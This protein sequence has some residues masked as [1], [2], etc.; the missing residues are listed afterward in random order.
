MFE[1]IVPI[2]SQIFLLPLLCAF[3]VHHTHGFEQVVPPTPR[4]YLGLHAGPGKNIMETTSAA[5][6]ELTT[7]LPNAKTHRLGSH[8]GGTNKVIREDVTLHTSPW[9]ALVAEASN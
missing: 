9:D 5:P 3:T 6:N 2:T 8:V 4:L 7:L 1:N